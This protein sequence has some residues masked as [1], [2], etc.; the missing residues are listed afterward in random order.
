MPP[1][2]AAICWYERPRIRSSISSARQ[3]AN[4][5]C[6]WQSMR[7]GTTS[8]PSASTRSSSRYSCGRLDSGPTQMMSLPRQTSAARAMAWMTPCPPSSR[9]EARRP[10]LART[11]TGVRGSW[12]HRSSADRFHAGGPSRGRRHSPR[13]RDASRRYP[14]RRSARAAGVA[15]PRRCPPP[16]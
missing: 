5:R 11:G 10:M 2:A 6:V 14:G 12:G 16:P 3:P 13:R 7:P 15:R 9:Q 8:R 1:P 4:A